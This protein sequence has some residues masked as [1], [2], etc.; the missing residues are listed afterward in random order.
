MDSLSGAN[1]QANDA[2]KGAAITKEPE[3]QTTVNQAVKADKT[4]QTTGGNKKDEK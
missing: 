4:P 1:K 2:D 3:N